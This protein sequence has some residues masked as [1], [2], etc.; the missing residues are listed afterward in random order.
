MRFEIGQRVGDYE[1][2]DVLDS[3]SNGAAYKVRNIL[4]QRF[5]M[6]R[7]LPENMQENRE[8]V[9]R[10]LREMKVHARLAHPNI[11]AFYNAS[12]IEG[13]LV[14]T[15]ELVEGL[16][17]A[18]LVAEGPI[19]LA[20]AVDCICQA[21]SALSYAHSRGIVHR[22]ITPSNMI[23]TPDGTVKL[24]GFGLAKAAGDP[25]L[26]QVGVMMGSLEYM[27]PEQV[28]GMT[29][30]DARSDIYSV[31]VVLYELATGKLPFECKSQFDILLAHVNQTPNPPSELQ[32]SLLPELDRIIL[33]ALAKEPSD[34]FQSAKEF[35]EALESV[36]P[37]EKA[38]LQ[39]PRRERAPEAPARSSHETPADA[40]PPLR[41]P[42][43]TKHVSPA[44]E[45]VPTDI[46]SVVLPRVVEGQPGVWQTPHLMAAGVLMFIVVAI[47]FWA[48]L[49]ISK[50]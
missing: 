46:P 25:Q 3:S 2:I 24:T 14:M 31:G 47:A 44:E 43:R 39:M 20:R 50:F 9:D 4:A 5:E 27:S 12:Q 42:D 8:K 35:G 16:T 48:F 32:P 1:I 23:V 41:R 18:E 21:L 28:K 29:T 11:V 7:I 49:T 33:R 13:Q 15:T 22:E 37:A 40:L 10:F 34:R 6:L 17:L 19:P 38:P 30:L 26:T 45:P 36:K